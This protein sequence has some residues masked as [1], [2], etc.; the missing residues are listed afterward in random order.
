MDSST[1]IIIVSVLSALFL[2]LICFLCFIDGWAPSTELAFLSAEEAILRLARTQYDKKSVEL[3]TSD[4][5][6][7]K[8][9]TLIIRSAE[10]VINMDQASEPI[11]P[12]PKRSPIVLL[13]GFAGALGFWF[14]NLQAIHAA[15]PDRDLIAID[16]LGFGRS[17]RPDV[18]HLQSAEQGEQWWIDSIERW[19]QVQDIVFS[20]YSSFLHF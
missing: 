19:R 10:V 7:C 11:K 17:S 1:V 14:K 9:N 12:S 16:L 3:Q 4:G 8:I 18:E 5:R 13:H 15:N 2:L 20:D 6:T